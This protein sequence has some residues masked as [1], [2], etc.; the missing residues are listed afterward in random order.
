[1]KWDPNLFFISLEIIEADVVFRPWKSTL[2]IR[3]ESPSTQENTLVDSAH[4]ALPERGKTVKARKQ[5][6]CA[7]SKAMEKES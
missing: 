3:R 1:V 2:L 5:Y 7:V 4:R 6:R